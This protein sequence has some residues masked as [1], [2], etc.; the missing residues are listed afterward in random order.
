MTC[1]HLEVVEQGEAV[2]GLGET[3]FVRFRCRKFGG[4]ATEY[5]WFPGEGGARLEI[6]AR[7]EQEC[8][9]WEEWTPEG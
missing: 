9:G 3:A 7:E 1:R 8:P 6:P 2:P 4:E 5:P